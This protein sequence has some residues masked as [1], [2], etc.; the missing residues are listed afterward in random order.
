MPREDSEDSESRRIIGYYP[1]RENNGLQ[2]DERPAPKPNRFDIYEQHFEDGSGLDKNWSLEDLNVRTYVPRH[3]E[4]F[5]IKERG[6]L[7]EA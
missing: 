7:L 5:P 4:K 3:R 2:E 1:Y 6:E